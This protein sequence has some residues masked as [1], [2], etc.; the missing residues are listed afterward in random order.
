MI[1]VASGKLVPHHQ[2]CCALR[3]WEPQ[4]SLFYRFIPKRLQLKLSNERHHCSSPRR[5]YVY[6]VFAWRG[7]EC[8]P[9]AWFQ[10]MAK[11]QAPQQS[12]PGV[13]SVVF[14]L[15][16][17]RFGST[18]RKSPIPR[19]IQS[20]SGHEETTIDAQMISHW[21]CQLFKL[22][23]HSDTFFRTTPTGSAAETH[24]ATYLPRWSCFVQAECLHPRP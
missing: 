6:A 5:R 21:W 2:S 17:H 7:L 18:Y 13:R 20:S 1:L 19:L 15:H 9:V 10:H 4:P 16:S 24:N 3:A 14:S 8:Q 22:H 11:S 23:R 12:F